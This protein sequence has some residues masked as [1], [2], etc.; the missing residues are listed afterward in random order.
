M[1]LHP[2]KFG[3]VTSSIVA[4]RLNLRQ[5]LSHVHFGRGGSHYHHAVVAHAIVK[6]SVLR[7]SAARSVTVLHVRVD[8][9]VVA[10]LIQFNNR[11]GNRLFSAEKLYWEK[12]IIFHV[13]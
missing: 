1:Q 6:S 9:S 10:L 8:N 12:H 2:F 7:G 5:L 11:L 13:N 4:R 3:V